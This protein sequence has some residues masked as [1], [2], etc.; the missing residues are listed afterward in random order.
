MKR[1]SRFGEMAEARG[2]VGIGKRRGQMVK[3][4]EGLRTQD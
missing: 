3:F 1:P 4:T 2:T